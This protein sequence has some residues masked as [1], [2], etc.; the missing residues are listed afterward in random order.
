VQPE[1][2]ELAAQSALGAL[3]AGGEETHPA[4]VAERAPPSRA[5]SVV[6][7]R[8]CCESVVVT[9]PAHSVAGS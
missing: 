5:K 9:T 6:Q 3:G 2:A 8:P 4:T 7:K 1:R